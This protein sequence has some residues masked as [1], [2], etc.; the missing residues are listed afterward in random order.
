MLWKQWTGHCDIGKQIRWF[1]TVRSQRIE[2]QLL[3][4]SS[5]PIA[6]CVRHLG[7]AWDPD[8][9]SS[10]FSLW[11]PFRLFNKSK[12]LPSIKRLHLQN[13]PCEHPWCRAKN[14][15]KQMIFDISQNNSKRLWK[16]RG[17][18]SCTLLVKDCFFV[19]FCFKH[20]T[21]KLAH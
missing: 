7:M 9:C 10:L 19:S 15:E 2:M 3:D 1:R 16:Y 8:P 17:S 13:F 11:S 21:F 20:W 6:T 5:W 14:C 12:P 18:T 4:F